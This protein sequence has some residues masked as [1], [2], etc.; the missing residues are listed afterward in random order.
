MSYLL[1]TDV[2]AET[3]KLGR[4]PGL[5]DWIAE[6]PGTH[7]YLS[8][9]TVGILE[10][11][12]A[13]LLGR[14]DQR[15]AAAFEGWLTDVIE[16]FGDRLI[17]VSTQIARE[18]GRLTRVHL[19]PSVDAFIAATAKVHGLTVVTRDTENVGRT[20]VQV[21]NPFTG[22]TPAPPDGVVHPDAVAG[23]S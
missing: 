14:G 1:D 9:L 23:L 20:D 5:M 19:L 22:R 16:E 11:A 4:D 10:Q 2:L 3:R 6:T 18:Y 12:I 8:T 15:Q 7:M 17:P 21:L 13:T